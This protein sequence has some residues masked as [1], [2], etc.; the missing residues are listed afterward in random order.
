VGYALSI[1]EPKIGGPPVKG[2]SK[3]K[4]QE[5]EPPSPIPRKWIMCVAPT[6]GEQ[7]QSGEQCPWAVVDT[8]WANFCC[9]GIIA[10]G[11]FPVLNNKM[12]AEQLKSG[13]TKAEAKFTYSLE[14]VQAECS[15]GSL[16]TGQS[17]SVTHVE[18]MEQKKDPD[19]KKG[20]P[21][22]KAARPA[23]PTTTPDPKKPKTAKDPDKSTSSSELQ[24]QASGRRGSPKQDVKP[25]EEP[26]EEEEDPS[27]GRTTRAS[28]NAD[29]KPGK[30]KAKANRESK[31][32]GRGC[33]PAGLARLKGEK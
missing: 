20:T 24:L 33:K 11:Q 15:T 7:G 28:K 8:P 10:P 1:L 16:L 2:Q 18:A 29:K 13:F 3:P 4:E 19:W 21:K 32:G 12:Y 25:D 27:T 17:H 9:L 23:S 5:G 14:I 6:G 22:K 30:A 31:P 26:S